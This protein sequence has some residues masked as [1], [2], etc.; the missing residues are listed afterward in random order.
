MKLWFDVRPIRDPFEDIAIGWLTRIEGLPRG[1]PARRL[2]L[3]DS[4]IEHKF[5]G[6][7]QATPR[8]GRDHPPVSVDVVDPSGTGRTACP[9]RSPFDSEHEALTD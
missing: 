3:S 2:R 7:R 9:Q 8:C 6:R 5:G 4:F 1:Y